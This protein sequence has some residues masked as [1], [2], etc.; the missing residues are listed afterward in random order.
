MKDLQA[1]EFPAHIFREKA[2]IETS[3]LGLRAKMF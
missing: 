3:D 2:D 1:A